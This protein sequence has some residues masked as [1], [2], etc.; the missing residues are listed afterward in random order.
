MHQAGYGDDSSVYIFVYDS[1]FFLVPIP[2]NGV[3]SNSGLW[4]PSAYP[5]EVVEGGQEDGVLRAIR[6]RVSISSKLSRSR[7]LTPHGRAV[8]RG[9]HGA[10]AWEPC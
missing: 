3:S 10:T 5:E 1:K 8:G 9:C 2:P 7:I 4:L 6:G